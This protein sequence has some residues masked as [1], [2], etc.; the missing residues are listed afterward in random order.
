[1]SIDFTKEV[2]SLRENENKEF[3]KPEAGSYVIKI[4]DE[5]VFVQKEFIKD[6]KTEKQEQLRLQ[7]EVN[8]K[9]FIWD[10]S[11]G[12]T[13]SSLYG[14]LMLVGKNWGALKGQ[15]ITLIVKRAK[16][17]NDYSILEAVPL[18]ATKEEKVV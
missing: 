8:N 10:V 15:G 2:T 14:Q 13:T 11:R 5:P 4:L 3:F 18:M 1:M 9:K 6:G 16:D 12:L 7:I 17:K